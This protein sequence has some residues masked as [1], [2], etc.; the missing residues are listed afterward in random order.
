MINSTQMR[1]S[2]TSSNGYTATISGCTPR[3]H[4]DDEV[5][6]QI[7]ESLVP[8]KFVD[9]IKEALTQ[10]AESLANESA[11]PSSRKKLTSE[12]ISE[13]ATKYDPSKMSQEEYDSFL[14]D[15]VGKGVLRKDEL[16][17]LGYHGLVNVTFAIGCYSAD[18]KSLSSNPYGIY[19]LAHGLSDTDGNAL[20]LAKLASL[21]QPCAGSTA[22]FAAAER[23]ISAFDA[24]AEV[25]EAIQDYREK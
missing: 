11:T 17:Q 24:M 25:L 8:S 9:Q 13:L 4:R 10:K 15:M 2:Y 22:F 23:K 20:A 1:F 16:G 6:T 12:D 5:L 7:R 14:D 18:A 19:G 21:W 3:V